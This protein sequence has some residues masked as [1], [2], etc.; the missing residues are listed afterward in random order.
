MTDLPL[1]HSFD[2]ATGEHVATR[3]AR[4][5]PKRPDEPVVPALATLIA[6]PAAGPNE[7]A[8]FDAA[9]GAWSLVPDHRGTEWWEADGTPHRIEALG[10]APAEGAVLN[11]PPGP[12][13]RHDGSGWV[14]DVAAEAR[15]LH[16]AAI[17]A[18]SAETHR[19]L[20]LYSEAERLS[21]SLQAVEANAALGGG[22]L[23]ADALVK[24]RAAAKGRTVLEEAARVKHRNT[25]FNGITLLAGLV[26]EAAEPMLAAVG[27]AQLAA[28][29]GEVETAQAALVAAV[30]ATLAEILGGG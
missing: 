9:A 8:V 14:Q 21:F 30:D 28:A 2:A 17:A 1:I 15:V 12:R 22:I 27:A 3:P 16:A 24:T 10:E 18:A 29:K 25:A 6:P 20:R 19:I 11:A 7:A 23:E 5:N 13:H 26:R 4:M